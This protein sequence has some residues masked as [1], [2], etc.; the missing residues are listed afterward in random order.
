MTIPATSAALLGTLLL[1]TACG[2][3]SDSVPGTATVQKGNLTQTA[4]AAGTT[5]AARQSKLSFSIAGKLA[6]LDVGAGEQVAAGQVLAELDPADLK[7]ALQ[8]AQAGQQAA[9][10]GV[11]AAEAKVQQLLASAKPENIAQANAGS[12]SA[13][14]KLQD[15]VNGGRPEQVAQA[16]AQLDA[17]K[18][19]LQLA[20]NGARQEQVQQ[21]QATLQAAQAK[22]QALQNGPRP[23]QVAVLQKQV[24][25]ARNNLYAAQITRDALCAGVKFG[26]TAPTGAPVTCEGGQAAVNAAQTGVDTAGEQLRLA[27]APPTAT[28]LQQAQSAVDQAKAQLA[29]LQSNTPQDVQ[30]ARDAVTQAAQGV[31]LARS[32][33]TAPQI[34]QARAA[35]TQADA[36]AQLAAR[37]FTDADVSVAQAGV[38]QAEAQLAQAQAAV[39]TAQTNLESAQLKAPAD[40]KVLQI[41][42]SPGEVMS[43]L[44]APTV[45]MVLGLGDVVVNVSLPET[46]VAQVKPGQDASVTF[47]SLPGKQFSATVADLSPAATTVQN[48]VSYVATIK[49]RNPGDEI[50]PGMNAS[51]TIY[52]LRKQDVLLVPNG[53]IQSYQGKDIVLLL[54]DGE[55][56]QAPIQVGASDQDNTE[57]VNGLSEGQRVA[58]ISKPLNGVSMTGPKPS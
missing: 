10:A 23:E 13:R 54:S 6:K 34:Q 12:D 42:A 5:V 1:L 4:S 33:Y 48:L 20:Q 56:K 57:I 55:K 29:M 49:L 26:Q 18:Q 16:Q 8:Q 45:V 31:S 46:A 25:T 38:Q 50:R 28:D 30:Q 2:V 11:A 35:V 47:D 40:G 22:I 36:A 32:P 53:A 41:N 14:A 39:T 52:T 9:Q 37:P 27:T 44:G 43:N 21:A 51:V 58:L 15:M 3:P 7:S 24:D 17:A 19:K